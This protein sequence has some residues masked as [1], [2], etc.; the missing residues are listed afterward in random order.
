M[1]TEPL[2]LGEDLF[3]DSLDDQALEGSIEARFR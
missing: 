1:H 3:F 2:I